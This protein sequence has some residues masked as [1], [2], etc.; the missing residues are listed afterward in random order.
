MPVDLLEE[1]RTTANRPYV[2]QKEVLNYQRANVVCYQQRLNEILRH[3]ST[4]FWKVSASFVC[5]SSSS[6][7]SAATKIS[8]EENVMGISRALVR[9]SHHD[10]QLPYATWC[11]LSLA[12]RRLSVCCFSAFVFD[13]RTI[14]TNES[15]SRF[16]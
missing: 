16:L 13:A 1:P 10:S 9:R 5:S 7:D 4:I 2:L 12:A 6:N 14:S 8:N 3:T 11:S 15:N